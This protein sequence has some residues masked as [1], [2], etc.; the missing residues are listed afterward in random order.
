MKKL[1][2]HA[3]PM[4]YPMEPGDVILTKDTRT[5]TGNLHPYFMIRVHSRKIAWWL[6]RL[7]FHHKSLASH[8]V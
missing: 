5:L 8:N 1:N 4:V 3:D 2:R 7:Q 6:L